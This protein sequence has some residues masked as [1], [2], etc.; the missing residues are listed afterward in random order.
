MKCSFIKLNWKTELIVGS[1]FVLQ[2]SSYNVSSSA[3]ATHLGPFGVRT[4]IAISVKLFKYHLL[5]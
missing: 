1:R 4:L 3:N 5:C 2:V